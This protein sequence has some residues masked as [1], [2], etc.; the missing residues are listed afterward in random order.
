MAG[1]PTLTLIG[2]V[3]A[4]PELRDAGR[5]RVCSFTVANN[6]RVFRD[7]NWVAGPAVF[8]RVSAWGQLG[9]HC[10]ASL[11]KGDH[12]VVQGIVQ[13]KTWEAR[14]GDK[15][16]SI[17]IR[18]EEVAAS[19]RFTTVDIARTSTPSATAPATPAAPATSPAP[20]AAAG[21]V[22]EWATVTPPDASRFGTYR[23]EETF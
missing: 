14:D 18:A 23:A 22:M 10:H 7:G 12:V 1:E 13:Q 3:T 4:D 11:K 8:M 20:A 16:T 5:D 19:L 6:S 9:E 2:N 15:R 17:E 21:P